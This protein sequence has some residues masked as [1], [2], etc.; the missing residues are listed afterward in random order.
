MSVFILFYAQG[1]LFEYVFSLWISLSF[2]HKVHQL[3]RFFTYSAGASERPFH[4]IFNK[5]FD[6]LKTL[7][8]IQRP[9]KTLSAGSLCG[10]LVPSAHSKGPKRTF[11][12]TRNMLS[13][14]LKCFIENENK[15]RFQGPILGQTPA[16][17]WVKGFYLPHKYHDLNFYRRF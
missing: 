13:Y 12:L 17:C 16:K 8:T 5:R 4:P 6:D 7:V 1:V 3:K 11:I 2:S 9:K 10:P 14:Q 15:H